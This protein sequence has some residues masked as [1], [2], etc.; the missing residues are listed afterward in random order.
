MRRSRLNVDCIISTTQA[1]HAQGDR[2]DE[3]MSASSNNI[4]NVKMICKEPIASRVGA[5]EIDLMRLHYSL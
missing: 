4:K 3:N 5:R 1:K 2:P